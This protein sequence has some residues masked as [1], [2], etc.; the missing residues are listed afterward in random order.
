[1]KK[2]KSENINKTKLLEQIEIHFPNFIDVAR[3][4]FPDKEEI[5]NFF[6]YNTNESEKTIKEV[7]NCKDDIESYI[8]NYTTESVY[9]KYLN[10]FFRQGDFDDFR[11]L[12][13]HISK[14]IYLLYEYRKENISSHGKTDYFRKIYIV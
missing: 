13:S 6:K 14:F 4:L 9:Y 1:L 3:Q 8:R 12:F 7:F 5:I 2:I 11:K 10:K